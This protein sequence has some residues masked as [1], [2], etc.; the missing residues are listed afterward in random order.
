M[1]VC[2]ENFAKGYKFTESHGRST[3]EIMD[4]HA[5]ISPQSFTFAI[6]ILCHDAHDPF[7]HSPPYPSLTHIEH[8]TSTFISFLLFEG[9]PFSEG[10]DI[11]IFLSIYQDVSP[12]NPVSNET[13]ERIEPG[14][15]QNDGTGNESRVFGLIDFVYHYVIQHSHVYVYVYCDPDVV[16]S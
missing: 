11:A 16:S 9:F 12:L 1:Y 8:F 2:S 7:L 6:S 14:F 5:N 15:Y 4:A 3:I 10:R 13:I